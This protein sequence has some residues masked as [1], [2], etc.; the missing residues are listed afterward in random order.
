[1]KGLNSVRRIVK[2][3]EGSGHR[4]FQ[5]IPSSVWKRR[6]EPRGTWVQI[7]VVPA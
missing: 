7:H 4:L 6:V 2:D 3:V 1:M 5:F